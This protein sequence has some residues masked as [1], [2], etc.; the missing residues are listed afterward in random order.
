M[1]R[2]E[3]QHSEDAFVI[4]LDGRFAGNDAEH[5][6]R[7]VTHCNLECGLIVNLTGVTFI[8]SAGEATLSFLNR[9]GANF[10]AEDVYT[11]DICE[12]LHLPLAR[13]GKGEV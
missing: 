12:R 5:V 2:A 9:L 8:D 13:N 4:R 11:L 7:L 10:V 3:I 6:R 1:L